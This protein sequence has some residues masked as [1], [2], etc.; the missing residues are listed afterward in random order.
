ME[1]FIDAQEMHLNNPKTFSVPSMSELDKIQADWFV[2]LCHAS[3]RFWVKVT[4]VNENIITGKISN[5]LSDKQPFKYDDIIQC[6][7]R[8]VYDFL[9]EGWSSMV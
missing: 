5:K 6:E 4:D 2:K 7:K 3:E 8:H 9:P 1:N